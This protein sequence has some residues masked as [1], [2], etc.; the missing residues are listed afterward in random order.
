MGNFVSRQNAAVEEADHST[1]HAYKYPP[2]IGN[3]FSTHF[4]MGGE[5]FDTPQPESYLFGENAD[6]NFLGNRPTAFPYPPPQANEPTKTL[7]SLVNIRKESVRFVRVPNDNKNQKQTDV[8][9]AATENKAK[10][11]ELSESSS[12]HT[13][14]DGNVICNMT[15]ATDTEIIGSP[16]S[17]CYNIE[18][19]FDSDAK[20]A[21]TIHYFCTE[22]VSLS[23]V[24]LTQ[25]EGLL[26]SF[27]S[28]TYHYDKGIN[29]CFS[30]PSHVFNPQ[31]IPEDD[32]VYNAGREQY[33]VAIHC[34]VEE[35]NEECRQSHT[36]ICVID[37]HPET[38]TYVLRALKQK[39]FVDGLCYLLQEIYGIENKAVNKSPLDE[40]IDDHGSECVICMSETRDTLILP[41]RHLCLCN[42]CADSLRYQANNCPIC[43]APFRAL[44]Q[45]RAVQKGISSSSS[46]MVHHQNTP[47]SVAGGGGESTPIDIPPGFIPVSLI[48]ALNG[49]PQVT[50]ARSVD[51][52]IMDSSTVA[53]STMTSGDNVKA[54]SPVKSSSQRRS[55]IKKNASTCTTT[56]E[57]STL[58][59]QTSGGTSTVSVVEI[60][61]DP[62][63]STPSLTSSS[64]ATS[65]PTLTCSP[66]IQEVHIINERHN[67]LKYQKHNQSG[68]N[69]DVVD[70]EDSENEK[71]SPLLSPG[72]RSKN[73]SCKSLKQVVASLGIHDD[74][75]DDDVVDGG[76]PNS[77]AAGEDIAGH[78]SLSRKSDSSLKRIK[79]TGDLADCE[80]PSTEPAGLLAA[81]L[82]AEESDYYT[83]DDTQNNILSPLCQSER[84][85]GGDSGSR[86]ETM[87]SDTNMSSSIGIGGGYSSTV[88]K[89]QNLHKKSTSVGNIV[90]P[91]NS[92]CGGVVDLKINNVSSLPDM[93]D[94]PVSGNSASTRSSSDSYSSSSSTKQLLSSNPSTTAANII[95]D[96]KTALQ[97]A[98]NV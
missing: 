32:L 77:D 30:Q 83:P 53:A 35:G 3:F 62:K 17:S 19:T 93:L 89:I 90:G 61:S 95:V 1:N 85:K 64:K 9:D 94:S 98:V 56:N 74:D 70:D 40:E 65:T 43:R 84:T 2:R 8:V 80:K 55:K 49:P 7:K 26:T 92:T 20:C 38:T 73:T 68:S 31:L 37:H 29:Q 52:D 25:R 10:T 88:K 46:H 75:D 27:T 11:R 66:N 76:S 5:R 33:P 51:H 34:V 14:V 45:I 21:I 60:E 63:K 78:D 96:D 91:A 81:N 42:S 50:R 44:L 39:I 86:H 13:Q 69:H 97:N 28:E 48:E 18:F 87:S 54:T 67:G 22:D 41:C 4:I 82:S 6:L 24:T 72:S 71:L 16:S 79:H 12:N 47:T 36:T 59:T 15:T 57:M 58:T 23:G